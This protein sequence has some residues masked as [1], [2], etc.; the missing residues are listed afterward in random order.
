MRAIL[1]VLIEPFGADISYLSKDSE[2]VKVQDIF[3]IGLV[4][5]FNISILG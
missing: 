4:K 1:I 5:A 2:K 3:S